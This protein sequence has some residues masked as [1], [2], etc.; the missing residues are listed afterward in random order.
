MR[1]IEGVEIAY[2]RSIYKFQLNDCSDVNILFGRNDSGKSN[3]LRALN[4][5]FDGKTNPLQSFDFPRDFCHARLSEAQAA[6]D[7]RKFVYVKIWFRTPANWRASL[8]DSFWVKK[9]WS[10]T[11]GGNAQFS[12]SVQNNQT[13]LTRFLNK[14]RFHYIPAIKD[15]K[16]F[17]QLQAEIYKVI[18]KNAEFDGSFAGFTKSLQQRTEELSS[19]LLERLGIV[20]A[21]STP[22]DLTDLF[23]SLDFVT[24]SETGDSY[25]LTLQ[26]GDGVQVRHIPPIL[27]F[28]SDN[29]VEDY[30]IWGFEEPENSLE[31][32]NA[33]KE[34]ETFRLFGAQKNKQIFLTSHSPAFFSLDGLD[35]RRFYVSRSEERGQ[36]L[37]SKIQKI[38]FATGFPGDLMG[39]TPHLPVISEYLRA[40]HEDIQRHAAARELL[41]GKIAEQAVPIVFVEG[42]SDKII[43]EKAW[44]VL[45]QTPLPVAFIP[46]GGTTKMESLGR[47]GPILNRLAPM[48]TVYTLV[49][50]DSEGRDVN[51]TARLAP[52]GKWVQ[53]NSNKVYWCRLPFEPGLEALMGQLKLPPAVWPGCLENLFP[54]VLRQRAVKDGALAFTEKPHAELCDAETIAK[55]IGHLTPR[56]D[57]GHYYLLTAT[58]Q[59]KVTFA[60]WIVSKADAEPEILEL[61]R[62]VMD[63]LQVALAPM[64]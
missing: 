4:L 25:S 40:A 49:D 6:A 64:P 7:I 42:D 18:S 63:G 12:T 32:V 21:V 55:I 1:L 13:Y 17:E 59:S 23:R 52:G 62:P 5:F 43:F 58:P 8:G 38:D 29:S 37:T 46:A 53:H 57:L 39:E 36:R 14:V 27:A 20:S 54:P 44:S 48:R 56:E 22:D 9:Q 47:D 45:M 19:G 28:L 11:T 61:L 15:R 35:I 51:S 10:I 26:R 24:T 33:I 16:I 50:N 30:H 41:E 2:F 34:A 60:E 3:V 31:L